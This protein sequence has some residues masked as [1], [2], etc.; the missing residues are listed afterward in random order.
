M[1]KHTNILLAFLGLLGLGTALVDAKQPQAKPTELAKTKLQLARQAFK[2]AME[3]LQAGHGA[4]EKVYLWSRRCLEAQRDLSDKKADKLAAL[5]EHLQCM[6]ELEKVATALYRT[7]K[8]TQNE[9][10]ASAFYVVEAE[11]WLMQAQKK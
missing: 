1:F 10:V 2:L 7:G 8:A 11:L 9:T 6:K 5:N 3:D 4:T